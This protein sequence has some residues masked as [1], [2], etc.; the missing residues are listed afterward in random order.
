MTGTGRILII[1]SLLGTLLTGCG[2]S[3]DNRRQ[4]IPRPVAYPRLDVPDSAFTTIDAGGVQLTVN[5]NT[6]VNVSSTDNGAWI[7]ISYDG[8]ASPQVYLTITDCRDAETMA[9]TLANRRER[10]ILNLGSNRYTL[11]ELSTP[12]GWTCAMTVARTS[13]TTPVQILAHNAD[14]VLSGA[15][16]IS[17]PDSVSANPDPVFIAPIV[18]AAERDM[19]VM[20]RS[21]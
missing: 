20:L 17:L 19:L 9:E 13:L 8:Y 21:L 5:E 12:S 10:M 14:K 3:A 1:V 2:G 4:A 15:F 7:D 18:D 11:T 6:G 16:T